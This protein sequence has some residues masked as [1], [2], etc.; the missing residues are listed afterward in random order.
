MITSNNRASLSMGAILLLSA[1]T[2]S[3]K[4]HKALTATNK[5]PNTTINQDSLERQQQAEDA[6]RKAAQEEADRKAAEAKKNES[7]SQV[8]HYFN[9]IAQSSNVTSAN[10][11]IQE[12]LTMFSSPQ[13]P[14]LIVI[15]QSGDQKDYDKP[16]TIGDYLNYLKDQKK[17]LNN[18]QHLEFDDAGKI[19]EVELIRK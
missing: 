14:V 13:T 6:R 17:N 5:L 7:Y 1:L 18:V 9:A 2:I 8:D 4:S 3:C 15:H 16:T 11:S 10:Q 12:A 19:K